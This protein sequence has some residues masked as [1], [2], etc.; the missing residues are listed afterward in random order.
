MN[1]KAPPWGWPRPISRIPAGL[2]GE[3]VASALDLAR[4]ADA[5]YSYPIIREF[6]TREETVIH[7][8]AAN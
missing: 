7:R 5:A 4:M 6:T 1:A 3:N 2:S 8:A